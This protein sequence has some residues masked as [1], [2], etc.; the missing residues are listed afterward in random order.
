MEKRVVINRLAQIC[1][2]PK[3]EDDDEY[4]VQLFVEALVLPENLV[5]YTEEEIRECIESFINNSK[6]KFE[7]E[8]YELDG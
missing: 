4:A 1:Y 6:M 7:E 5:Q 3:T 8:E 2:R